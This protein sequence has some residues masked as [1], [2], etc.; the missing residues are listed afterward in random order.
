MRTVYIS[1]LILIA[2]SLSAQKKLYKQAV[3]LESAE[4]YE[5]AIEKYKEVLYKN[6]SHLEAKDG[7]KR[8][9]QKII[10]QKL[11]D[12]F[13]ARNS[14]ELG[15][16][17]KLFDEVIHTRKELEYFKVSIDIPSYY[18]KDYEADKNKLEEGAQTEK[19]LVKEEAKQEKYE[20]AVQLFDQSDWVGAWKIF[21]K[22]KGYEDSNDY[23]QKIEA[24]AK[25]IS[26]VA[27]AKNQFSKEETL[28]NSLLS[29]LFKLKNPLIKVIN[30]DNLDQ[31]IEEQK[32]GLSGLIDEK[33][34]ADLGRILGVENM[35][36]TRVL[37]YNMVEGTRTSQ[38][39]T[40]YTASINENI[41]DYY[42]VTY[43]EY[44]QQSELEV[45]FQY[46]LIDVST[47]EILMSKIIY[48]KAEDQLNY[49]V[50]QG[51]PNS[52]YPSDGSHIYTKGKERDAFLSLFGA[53][54]QPLTKK[55]MDVEVQRSLAKKVAISLD[56]Y[57]KQ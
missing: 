30:R 52:L 56:N 12:Y 41:K 2:T 46:Q 10:D 38:N 6:A 24:K 37:N 23:L 55:E 33:S 35:L 40:A 9:A 5:M 45:S 28:R 13:I 25:R 3:A 18:Y 44:F 8:S 50:Y 36:I 34:A 47:A 14:D 20:Q 49:A 4:Q 43:Q 31:L 21:D 57:F 16:A 29:E 15:E 32:L 39:K 54:N 17:V 1:L 42:P 19:S 27:H 11:S 7:L 51:D 26:I 53:R 48:E 22:L